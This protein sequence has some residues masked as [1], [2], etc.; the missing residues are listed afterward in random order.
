[1]LL[2]V[3]CADVEWNVGPA[4][5]WRGRELEEGWGVRPDSAAREISFQL[6]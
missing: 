1:M 3:S 5:I 2:P 6:V 4:S